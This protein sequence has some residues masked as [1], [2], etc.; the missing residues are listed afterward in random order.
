MESLVGLLVIA[1]CAAGMYM[2]M[3]M[4]MGGGG[5]EVSGERQGTAAGAEHNDE[6]EA[7]REEVARLRT[8]ERR[9]GGARP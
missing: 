3:R 1:A 9:G 6:V 7:L 4:M 2:M 8:E 5:R